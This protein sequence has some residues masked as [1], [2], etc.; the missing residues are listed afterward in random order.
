MK[1]RTV[2]PGL[3]LVVLLGCAGA[4]PRPDRFAELRALDAELLSRDSATLTLEHWCAEH[5]LADPPRVVARRIHDANRPIPDDLREQLRVDPTQPLAYRHVQLVCGEHVL[6]EAD[7]WYVPGRLTPEMNRRLETTD[8]P[9]G[10]VVKPLGFRRRTLSTQLLWHP[11]APE[12]VPP[13]D[14]LRHTAVLYTA[15]QMP[16]S[17]VVETYQNGLF[18]PAR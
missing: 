6:S 16:F 17:A 15:A 7:N 3:A 2:V 1:R 10:K 14:L 9:F 4:P 12:R 13:R 11:R 8:E 5:H 18:E